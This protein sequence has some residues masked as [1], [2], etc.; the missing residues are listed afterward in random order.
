[1]EVRYYFTPVSK[2][3][4]GAD[5]RIRY[6]LKQS[7]YAWGANTR[8]VNDLKLGDWICFYSC[9]SGGI[10]A[11]ARVE[12]RSKRRDTTPPKFRKDVPLHPVEKFPMGFEVNEVKI[13][14]N[15]SI[16]VNG[17]ICSQLDAF[18]KRGKKSSTWDKWFRGW[19]RATRRISRNDFLILTGQKK[20][21]TPE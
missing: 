16:I 20:M 5:K 7:V 13:F 12:T 21:K 4:P 15:N 14:A 18:K 8:Y 2:R 17:R 11:Y 3:L 9:A 1:M 19:K 6:P 10:V